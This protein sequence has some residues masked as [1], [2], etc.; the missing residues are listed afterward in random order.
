[1]VQPKLV[2]P[3]WDRQGDDWVRGMAAGGPQHQRTAA[4]LH[5]LLVRIARAELFRRPSAARLS[6]PELDDL[7]HDCAT[8]AFLAIVA[9]LGAYRGES[10]FSTWA[11]RFVAL[12][13]SAKLRRHFGYYAHAAAAEPDWNALPDRY[14]PNPA[15]ASERRELIDAVRRALVEDLSDRQR[16]VFVAVV[17]NARPPEAVA[18]ELR[19]SRGAVYKTLFEAR[20]KLRA[21]ITDFG[22]GHARR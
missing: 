21:V 15:D 17:M 5:G 12:E 16:Q 19:T 3:A 9:K 2:S 13:V 20:R 1:M 4:E 7:A 18:A 22:Q 6:G 10:R 11:Y 14:S 8:D